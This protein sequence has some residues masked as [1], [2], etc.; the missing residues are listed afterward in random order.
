MMRTD[1]RRWTPRLRTGWCRARTAVFGDRLGLLVFL[2]AVVFLGLCW[3]VGFFITDTKTVANL[4]ANVADGRLAVVETPYSLTAAGQ[5]GLVEVDGQLYGRN[6]GQVYLA[7]PIVWLL[8]GLT[9]IVDLRLLLAGL[10]SLA[11]VALGWTAART[12]DRPGLADAGAAAGMA[13]AVLAVLLRSA[14]PAVDLHIVA[15][16]LTTILVAAVGATALYRLLA[17]VDG[18]R[19]GL[20]AGL[21]LILATPVG[22]WGTLPKRHVY[23]ATALLL[24]C[25]SFALARRSGGRRATLARAGAYGAVAITAAIHSFEGA[26]MLA[27]LLPFDLATARSATLRQHV[28]VLLVFL[29]ALSPMLATNL[30]IAGDP[31]QPPRQLPDA[32]ES[33]LPPDLGDEA[34][35]PPAGGGTGGSAGDGGGGNTQ[36][37]SDDGGGTDGSGSESGGPALTV[38][39]PLVEFLATVGW[40]VGYMWRT[41][42]SGLASLQE[43]GR[44][45][46]VFVRS[47]WI[48]SLSYAVNDYEAIELALLEAMPIAGA[49]LGLPVLVADRLRETLPDGD[50]TGRL[51]AVDALAGTLAVVFLLIYLPLL[52][53][54]S[55]LTLRYALPAMPLLLYLICRLGP[56]RTAIRTAPA[57]LGRSYWFFLIVG[58]AGLLVGL[59]VVDPAVGE[60]FQLHALLGLVGAAAAA[61]AIGS[62]PLHRDGRLVAPGLALPAALTTLFLAAAALWHFQYG[63]YA[64]D[65][66]RVLAEAL[67]AIG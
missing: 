32:G 56:V 63:A 17:L 51:T 9:L 57:S 55:M 44:L 11:V 24:V 60:A 31:L 65:L 39:A 34:G 52:P 40:I 61:L 58:G 18:W 48:P 45:Y 14:L 27:V 3:R 29:L 1:I 21:G 38:P 23:T 41:L 50:P 4:L 62:W 16:P 67:P 35:T 53:L 5:P 47:G 19:V 42:L 36:T 59:P 26:F 37:G 7:T 49:L 43:P 8:D 10:W 46:H 64:L 12:F 2:V 33:G 13:S 66:A 22:F 54:F 30:A 15:L 25:Y 28:A 6:Y 20:A